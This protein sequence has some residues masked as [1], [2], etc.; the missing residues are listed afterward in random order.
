MRRIS[1]I[2]F[3]S[4]SNLLLLKEVRET[5]GEVLGQLIDHN[6]VLHIKSLAGT[7]SCREVES[8]AHNF[9]VERFEMVNTTEEF[10]K[11]SHEELAT[12]LGCRHALT[13]SSGTDALLAPTIRTG[14]ANA[15]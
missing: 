9:L 12:Y 2:K 13:M 10:L 8:K 14:T 15:T 3:L 1:V 7:F 6:N 4:G 5:A 11:L